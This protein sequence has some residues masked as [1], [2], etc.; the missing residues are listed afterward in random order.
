MLY[1]KILCAVDFSEYSRDALRTAMATAV[2]SGAGGEV[3]LVHVA[4][5]P[6]LGA[7]EL[8][9]DPGVLAALVASTQRTL[10]DWAEEARRLGSAPVSTMALEGVPWDQ[11]VTL[12]REGDFDLVVM[13]THGRTG[14]KHALLGSVAEKVVRHAPCPV[15]VVRRKERTIGGPC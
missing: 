8:P 12:A 9:F 6:V 3:T 10:A 14:L 13:G 11:I 1:R 2:A 7:P 5:I 4:Q 15:L